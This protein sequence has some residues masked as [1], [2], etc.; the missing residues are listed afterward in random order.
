MG[1]DLVPPHKSVLWEAQR[2]FLLCGGSL[3]WTAELGSWLR[4]QGGSWNLQ[5]GRWRPRS[6]VFWIQMWDSGGASGHF[7]HA[8]GVWAWVVMLPAYSFCFCTAIPTASALSQT[9]AAAGVRFRKKSTDPLLQAPN[10]GVPSGSSLTVSSHLND[11]VLK[12]S[13]YNTTDIT[14]AVLWKIWSNDWLISQRWLFSN[15]RTWTRKQNIPRCYNKE[16]KRGM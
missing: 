2:L 3:D 14:A 8:S 5:R 12:N 9:L 15:G 1:Q 4:H 16:N 11:I 10:F 6:S 13:A 7:L